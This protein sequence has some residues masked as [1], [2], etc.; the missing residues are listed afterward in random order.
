[1]SIF[2]P[3]FGTSAQLDAITLEDGEM[4]YDVTNEK[5]RIGD[6]VTLGGLD[7]VSGGQGYTPPALTNIVVDTDTL[8]A[9]T[10]VNTFAGSVNG[11]VTVP[12]TASNGSQ[13]YIYVSG[14]AQVK[15]EKA[16]SGDTIVPT[17]VIADGVL[18]L[19]YDTVSAS[20]KIVR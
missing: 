12:D 5:F 17:V 9:N 20:Y 19:E 15:I 10:K 11:T 7:L 6:G 2:K 3:P 14:T 1:M 13:Y 18:C 8:Q 16:T 4:V